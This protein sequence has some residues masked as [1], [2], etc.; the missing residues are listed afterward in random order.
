MNKTTIASFIRIG[1][2]GALALVVLLAVNAC[3][4]QTPLKVSPETLT[5]TAG[6]GPA[7]FTAS[8]ASG[9]V[10]WSLSPELGTISATSGASTQYTP[11]VGVQS[12][13]TVTLTHANGSVVRFTAS[14]RIEIQ[15][16][17]TVEVTAA[18]LNVHVPVATFDGM[19]N[20]TTLNAS[21]GVVSPMYTPGAG[22]I[23]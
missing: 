17:A 1:L 19:I 3:G 5:V 2:F 12:A 6:D 13:Q 7:T 16:N 20:C 15:A 8:G 14:G 9:T 4:G 22:N 23:W 18:A 21:V 11:P 10:S